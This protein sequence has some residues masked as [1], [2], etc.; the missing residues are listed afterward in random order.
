MLL[1][2]PRCWTSPRSQIISIFRRTIFVEAITIGGINKESCEDGR[3]V[4]Y[5]VRRLEL[6]T[7]PQYRV[8]GLLSLNYKLSN[9]AEQ[10]I[11]LVEYDYCLLC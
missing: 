2:E 5:F 4:F 3:L 7:L 11:Y 6:L 9:K 10:G 8:S 1:N